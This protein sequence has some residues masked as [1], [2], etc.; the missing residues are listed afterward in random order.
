MRHGI[1]HHSRSQLARGGA[2]AACAIAVVL[3]LLGCEPK[4]AP[5]SAP[6]VLV[7]TTVTVPAGGGQG[8][9]SFDASKGQTLHV[10]M[11]S[12]APAV[13]PYG[14]LQEPD[15]TSEYFPK[16][17]SA[18]P[19]SNAGEMVV[20]ATGPHQLTVFDGSNTGG[21]VAVKIEAK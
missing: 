5:S 20:N 8:G 1:V 16:N 9:I 7:Q 19:G 4:T 15:G 14:Y 11:S 21:E 3:A 18:K 2:S 17:E 12:R 13:E 10:T 6:R